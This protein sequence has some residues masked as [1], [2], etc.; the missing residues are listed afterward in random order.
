MSELLPQEVED[1]EGVSTAATPAATRPG[2]PESRGCTSPAAPG[3]GAC[4]SGA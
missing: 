1:A 2:T 4:A 3:A